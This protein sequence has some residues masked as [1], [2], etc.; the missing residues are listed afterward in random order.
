MVKEIAD[1]GYYDGIKS[2]DQEID[3]EILIHMFTV[4][5]KKFLSVQRG[6][7][8]GMPDIPSEEKYFLLPFQDLTTPIVE[9]LNTDKISMRT[10]PRI[11]GGAENANLVNEI[12]G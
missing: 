2:I 4:K 7:H 12:F 3:L 5:G 10:M 11:L 1:L 9:D 6:K 8:R